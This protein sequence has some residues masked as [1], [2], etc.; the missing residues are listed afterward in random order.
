MAVAPSS[1]LLPQLKKARGVKM[2]RH[3]DK[4]G[5]IEIIRFNAPVQPPFNNVKLRQ[6]RAGGGGSEASS[7][8]RRIGERTRRCGRRVSASSRRAV[9]SPPRQD[10]MAAITGPRDWDKAKKLVAESG[11][12]GEKVGHHRADRLSHTCRPSAR[13]HATC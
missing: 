8:R 9:A 1:D 10:G 7:C 2:L 13:W 5:N 3:V 11:Y 12:K 6:R 4:I